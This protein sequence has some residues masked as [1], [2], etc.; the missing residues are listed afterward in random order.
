MDSR[1]RLVDASCVAMDAALA[2]NLAEAYRC[3]WTMISLIHD[4]EFHE[5]LALGLAAVMDRVVWMERSCSSR[6][7]A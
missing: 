7:A 5:Q 3:A 6:R 1:E 4:I 2:G